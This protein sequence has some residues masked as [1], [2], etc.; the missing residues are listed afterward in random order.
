MRSALTVSRLRSPLTGPT[1]WSAW[2]RTSCRPHCTTPP[3]MP[4]TGSRLTTGASRPG[5][6]RWRGLKRDRT[7]SVVIR[8]HAFIQ[9]LRRGHY[10]LGVDARPGLTLAAAFDDLAQVICAANLTEAGQLAPDD[11]SMQQ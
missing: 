9:N 5:F 1:P 4:T 7:A 2:S 3:N 11:Q 6:V 10:E 8:G